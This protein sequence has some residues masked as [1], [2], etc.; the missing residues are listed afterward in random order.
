[1]EALMDHDFA[2]LRAV[3]PEDFVFHDHRRAGLGRVEGAAAF[4]ASLAPLA[5]Q[6]PDFCIETLFT[7]AIGEH[8]MLDMARVF[9][10]LA[11][12]GGAFETFYARLGTWRG[13]RIVAMEL[14]EPNDLDRARARFTE[15]HRESA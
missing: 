1:M 15:L 3:L 14:F 10:T 12:S 6:A 11:A 5:E 4:V 2:R 13:D 9:G 8:G 7:I